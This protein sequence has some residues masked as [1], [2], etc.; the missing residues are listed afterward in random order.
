MPTILPP[1][2]VGT[3]PRHLSIEA[4]PR[5]LMPLR[6][7]FR[8][9]QTTRKADR[10]VSRLRHGHRAELRPDHRKGIATIEFVY[11]ALSG[12]MFVFGSLTQGIAL[13]CLTAAL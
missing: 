11:P 7:R 3:N 6:V 8:H 2:S 10:R 4:D 9:E 1:P 13:G 5:A 12:R